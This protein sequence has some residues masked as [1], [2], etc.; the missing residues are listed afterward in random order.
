MKLKIFTL[1]FSDEADGF[2]DGKVRTFLEDK[3]VVEL[4]EHF[5]IR[6]KTPYLTLV[7]SYREIAPEDRRGRGRGRDPR[8]DLDPEEVRAYEALRTWRAAKARQEGIA[9]YMIA[10]NKQLAAFVKRRA[11]SKS[12]LDGVRGFG[13]ARIDKHGE[14]ILHIVADQLETP[15]QADTDEEKAQ[16]KDKDAD[17]ESP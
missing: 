13:Q 6:G 5:F 1:R 10:T 15:V 2:D 4:M 8:D 12:D 16:S 3:E 14:E 9:A 7:V 11:A 17:I